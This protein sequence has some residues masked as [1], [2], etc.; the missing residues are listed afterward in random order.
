MGQKLKSSQSLPA[1]KATL[2]QREGAAV[3]RGDGWR[4]CVSP[5]QVSQSFWRFECASQWRSDLLRC[6]AS[7]HVFVW[8][9]GLGDLSTRRIS[10]VLRVEHSSR[11][12]GFG[13]LLG[14]VVVECLR[15]KILLAL[16]VT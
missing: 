5:A 6:L 7:H 13:R 10:V 9:T 14:T 3:H 2:S 4:G 12:G 15:R 8:V 16:A 1:L 11:A